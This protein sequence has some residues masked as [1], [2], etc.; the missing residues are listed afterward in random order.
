GREERYSLHRCLRFQRIGLRCQP[1]VGLLLRSPLQKPP[2]S[3]ALYFQ[4]PQ[5]RRS[6]RL[7]DQARWLRGCFCPTPRKGK[8]LSGVNKPLLSL[9]QQSSVNDGRSSL[10]AS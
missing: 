3:A 1:S 6:L 8:S 10:P 5:G 9:F 2:A 7:E 4:E